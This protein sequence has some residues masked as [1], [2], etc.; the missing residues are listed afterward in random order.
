MQASKRRN[1]ERNSR[2]PETVCFELLYFAMSLLK[3]VAQGGC[4]PRLCV[5]DLHVI[6]YNGDVCMKG[7][8]WAC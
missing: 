5:V 3:A 7:R 8:W 6:V 1:A 4:R 2:T